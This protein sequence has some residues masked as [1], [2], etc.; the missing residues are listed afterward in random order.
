MFE[1]IERY[2]GAMESLGT[3]ISER[4]QYSELKEEIVMCMERRT[5]LHMHEESS[6]VLK[7][8]QVW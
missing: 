5:R 8:A 1:Y 2:C 7:Y 3:D 4:T 6:I